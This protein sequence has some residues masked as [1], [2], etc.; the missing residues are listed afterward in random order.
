MHLDVGIGYEPDLALKRQAI[1]DYLY[2]S[3]GHHDWYAAR[4]Y[5]CEILSFVNV[6]AQMFLLDKLFEGRYL[7]FGLD[8]I[9]YLQ[10]Q[11]QDNH[12]NPMTL[13]FPQ[14]TKCKVYRNGPSASIEYIDA[15]CVLPLNV[16]NEKIYLFIWFWFV[17]LS[18]LT[19]FVLMFGLI[20]MASPSVRVYMLNMRFKMSQLDHLDTI[21]RKAT[22]GDWFLLYL[23]GKNIDSYIMKDIIKDLALR[24][25]EGKEYDQRMA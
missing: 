13:I 11:D 12:R 9:E 1:V 10:Q 20:I 23:V 17:F 22:I 25:N 15:L 19:F 3:S 5:F 18:I 8:V 7:R 21:V 6:I 2:H 16:M 14:Q 4:Y 24:Y